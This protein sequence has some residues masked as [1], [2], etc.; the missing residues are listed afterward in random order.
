MYE[1]PD[2][3]SF[4]EGLEACRSLRPTVAPS[5]RLALIGGF[6]PRRCGIATFTADIH[7]SLRAA[8]PEVAVDVYAMAPAATPTIFDPV[9][10][11]AIT[12]GDTDSFIDTAKQIEASCADIV[13][14]QHEFGL[15][16]GL[17]GDMVLELVDRVSA[18]LIVT[19]HTVL[20]EPDADQR[21]VM[22]RLIARATKL[23]VMSE[24]SRDLL[25]SVYRADDDQ[26]AM[27]AHG[28]PDRPFGRASQFKPRFGFAGKQV[29]L[30]FGLLSPGKG[31]EAVI[32]ALPVIVEDHPDFLYCIAGATHPNLLAQEGEA[33]RD[34]LEALAVSLGVEA[35]VRWI[36]A[37]L[38][39]DDLLDLIEAADIYV[40]PYTGAQQS[41]SGTLSYA[42]ALGKA[43]ISTPY[44]HAVELLADDHGVLVPF[45][46]SE[47]I[48]NEI[49]YLLG[50]TDRLLT[51]QRRAYDRS[52]DMI[53]PVFAERTCAL[54][55]EN[56]VLP[57]AAPIPDRIGIDGFLR[58]CDDTG[59]LQH[60][61][62]MI[63]DRAHGYCVDDNARALM[64]MHRLDDDAFRRCGQ[65]TSVFAAFVQ[66]AWNP[67]RA[68]FRN[69]MGFGRDWLEDVGSEDS[70]GRTLWALGATARDAREPGQRLWAHELFERT[71]AS[72][73]DFRSPRAIAFAMLGADFVL[74]THPEHD[75]ANRILRSGADR[76]MT[77]YEVAARPN[78][79]WF[80]PVLAYDNCRL[81]EAML[82]AGVRME[83]ADITACGV[84][85]LR[86]IN[87]AQ[88]SPD[89]YY[90]PVGSD[91]F[92]HD[93]E[94]PRPF[95]QQPLEIWAAIDA[96]SVA[97]DVTGDDIWLTHA[98]RAYEWF[99]GRNDRGVIVGDPLTGTSRDGINPRGLNLNEG[100]ESV[101]AYQ[102]A[103]Y[104][105]R[106]F[107]RK[108]D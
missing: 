8:A 94:I 5:L 36:N 55:A 6:L 3:T 50:D 87:D 38:D 100:A 1:A 59:I 80:E 25:R 42:M 77:L 35:H 53:W 76:L 85:T 14:L 75:L 45:N 47:A 91:S 39:T 71:A 108:V 12:E 86:W 22:G 62:H 96:A 84:D 70:C 61:V 7:A 90:R 23:V 63:P 102:H 98:Q 46:D 13:W 49:R 48:A 43:V 106:D 17:A 44:V 64:L 103:T 10:C 28:V 89:G 72:A 34:R 58:I 21:R 88:I 19:L 65:L 52:R 67:D 95:D 56:R 107:I 9:V 93:Y 41:T 74:A 54:I 82:R 92:G 69:F 73:L 4:D 24:R 27:I 104:A 15:F 26:I 20:A 78:W 99:S 33:Y 29:A 11:A 31:I 2:R 81:P 97:Y 60:S 66:H 16:G 101:L 83:R 18:P 32:E 68:E 57:K 37:F 40:T 79:R 51:L 30:T 105:I